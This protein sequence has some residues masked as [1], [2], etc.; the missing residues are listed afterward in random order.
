MDKDLREKIL[1]YNKLCDE[2][3]DLKNEIEN[4]LERDYSIVDD[5][6]SPY[7]EDGAC[8][9]YEWGTMQF[10]IE[11]LDKVINFIEEFRKENGETPEDFDIAMHFSN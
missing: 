6:N 11:M 8:P 9:I 10:D 5:I 4:L 1:K 3:N 7:E 2:V